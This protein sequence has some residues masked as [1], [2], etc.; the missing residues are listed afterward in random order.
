VALLSDVLVVN[1]GSTS[2]NPSIVDA[3]ERSRPV[4]S[5]AAAPRVDAVGHRLSHGGERFSAPTLIDEN[6]L[7]KFTDLIELAPLH[8]RRRLKPLKRVGCEISVLPANRRFLGRA[9]NFARARVFGRFGSF[10]GARRLGFANSYG[11]SSAGHS[12]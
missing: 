11:S 2:L 8:M 10:S 5:L 3:D 7:D 9:P 12:G 1:A 4:A 6:M